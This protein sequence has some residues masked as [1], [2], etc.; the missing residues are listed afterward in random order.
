MS[1]ERHCK[2]ALEEENQRLR[3][4]NDRLM[5]IVVQMKCTLN[6]LV[7]EYITERQRRRVSL[8]E[9]QRKMAVHRWKVVLSESCLR[10]NQRNYVRKE[11][12]SGRLACKR[13]RQLG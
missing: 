10:R 12:N 8:G 3:E 2:N 6:R 13:G 1:M 5:D 11:E 4:E 7:K 9:D